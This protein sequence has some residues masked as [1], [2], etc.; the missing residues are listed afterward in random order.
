MKLFNHRKFYDKDSLSINELGANPI[1]FFKKWFK[2][3]EK[4][5][6]IIESNAMTISTVDNSG[7]PSSRV[8]L[9]KEIK[10]KSLI[11]F[12]NYKSKK[13][14]EINDNPN[15]CA[16]FYWA[17]LE[18]QVIFKGIAKKT[19]ED[20]SDIYFKSRPFSSQVSAIISNQSETITT[21]DDLLIKYDEFYKE[22]K[23][24]N[25]KRPKHWGGI[26]LFIH[27]IEFWQGRGNRLHNRIISNLVKGKWKHNILSP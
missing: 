22:N 11:F 13:G 26:E 4:N 19:S 16:S 20:Y 14:K 18:R 1:N 24:S 9:L 5:D 17:P 15:I 2:D 21:Y 12:T 23:N 3:A 27:E 7:H 25:L 6:Q 8:V 10:D